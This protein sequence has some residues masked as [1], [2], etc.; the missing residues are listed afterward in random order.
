MLWLEYHLTLLQIIYSRRA[1]TLY[2]GRHSVRLQAKASINGVL[3]QMDTMPASV[4]RIKIIKKATEPNVE[5][6]HPTPSWIRRHQH[7]LGS[8]A[9]GSAPR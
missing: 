9:A 4:N 7:H 2:R 3:T 8:V 1:K 5:P 6:N